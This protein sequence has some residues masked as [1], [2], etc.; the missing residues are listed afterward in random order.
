MRLARSAQLLQTPTTR[1][2]VVAAPLVCMAFALPRAEVPLPITSGTI[3][4][5]HIQA[6]IPFVMRDQYSTQVCVSSRS[7]QPLP[8]FIVP[9][10]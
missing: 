4:P 6:G 7:G 3:M 8:P 10:K 2:I 5:Q 9:S 1:M